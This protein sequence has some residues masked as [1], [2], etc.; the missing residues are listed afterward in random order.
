MKKS[1]RFQF[2]GPMVRALCIAAVALPLFGQA[3]SERFEPPRLRDGH[4]NLQGLWKTSGGFGPPEKGVP[5]PPAFDYLPAAQAK[6]KELI[7]TGAA[8]DIVA[9]CITASVPRDIL[10]PP[11]PMMI[12]QDGRYFVMLHEFAHDVRI[13]PVDASPH[14]KNYSALGGDSRGHWEGDTV[15]V[16]V[17]N[18]SK[19]IRWLHMGG[20]FVDENAHVVERYTLID[21]DTILYDVTIEDPTVLAKPWNAKLHLL[22][23][24]KDDQILDNACREGE[25]DVRHYVVGREATGR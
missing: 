24:P 21:P 6:K 20:D 7:A 13:V 16:D 1:R 9:N 22:R 3:S 8:Q 15:V 17:K 2:A 5:R 14:P 19:G 12:V 18:F 10:E 25:R 23:Q 4:P 11:Y